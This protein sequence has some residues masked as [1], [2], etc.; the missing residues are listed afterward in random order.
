MFLGQGIAIKGNDLP[1]AD[2]LERATSNALPS[3]GVS[4][5]ST[6]G[7]LNAHKHGALI[8][9]LSAAFAEL[10]G[11]ETLAD[12]LAPE[13]MA[14]A[15]KLGIREEIES[16][17]VADM[18][19]GAP[20]PASVVLTRMSLMLDALSL[21]DRK[22]IKHRIVHSPPKT[23]AEIGADAGVTR[24]RIRQ[25]QT[26]LERKIRVASGREM[27]VIASVM[28]ERFG[29]LVYQTEVDM[30]M[31]SLE[32]TRSTLVSKL[33]RH[34]LIAQIGYTPES[35]VYWDDTARAVAKEIRASAERLA[36]DVGLVD[37]EQ[38]VA[39]LPSEVWRPFWPWIRKRCRLHDLHG[40]L[41]IRD[42]G[43][44]RAKAA[45]MSLGRPATREEIAEMCGFTKNR[46]GS[47]LSAIPS[48]VKAD[49]DRWAVDA[50]IDD[51]YD[52]IVG[53]IIQ[54]IDEDGGATTTKRLL[55][56]LPGRFNVSPSSVRAY[57][58]TPK[59]AIRDGRVSL[60][61]AS[62]LR[63]RH[64]DDVIDGRDSDGAPYW[65]F[66]VAE[67]FFDGRN[68]TNVPPEFA[69]ALGCRPD[70]RKAIRIANLPD[71]RDL[72]MGW[73]LASPTGAWIGHLAE[74]LQ[75]LK[76][77][78]GQRAKVTIKGLAL[79]SLTAKDGEPK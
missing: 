27:Q 56:E 22:I 69:T 71:C 1:N 61:R 72:S 70:G 68:V 13:C 37:A 40:S 79:V 21:R 66:S 16:V 78:P 36:D 54:R 55:R 42:S 14:L 74:A 6:V 33:F 53:E 26:N 73:P 44:A 52:G 59:F 77:H 23:L 15:S 39:E 58:H 50:W 19:D 43:K 41:A 51:K 11:A 63:L 24:E 46:A 5:S 64:L 20:G 67:R 57:M 34:E 3:R 17:R 9:Q 32:S 65:T 31:E 8:G 76:L 10:H 28:K 47:H 60:A 75:R 35:G 30:Y 18:T 49:K 62:S 45:L 2:H 12:L 7:S 48:V 29:H 25:L 4:V 38:L